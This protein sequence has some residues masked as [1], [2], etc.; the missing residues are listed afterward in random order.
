MRM[1]APGDVFEDAESRVLKITEVKVGD[2][3]G[4]EIVGKVDHPDGGGWKDYSTTLQV[5]EHVWR[6]KEPRWAGTT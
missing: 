2:P 3:L 4:R 5:W 1:P 6:D